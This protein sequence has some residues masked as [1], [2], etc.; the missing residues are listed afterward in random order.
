MTPEERLRELRRRPHERPPAIDRPV[1]EVP[2]RPERNLGPRDYDLIDD[3]VTSDGPPVE[4][5]GV[6]NDEVERV[7]WV[8]HNEAG[9]P[10]RFESAT[11]HDNRRGVS[12]GIRE[13][14]WEGDRCV[15]VRR[16][17]SDGEYSW[18]E[19]DDG[20][21]DERGLVLVRRNGIL[22]WNRASDGIEE[23][24]LPADEALAIWVEAAAEAA[25]RAVEFAA[26]PEGAVIKV[27]ASFLAEPPAVVI[28]DPGRIAL[29]GAREAVRRA[30]E[31]SLP[32]IRELSPD[33]LHALRSL[34]TVRVLD[35]WAEAG[36]ALTRRLA[37]MSWP[38]GAIAVGYGLG[39]DGWE[40]AL[41][42]LPAA[43]SIATVGG[44][45]SSREEIAD[46]LE[47][48]GLP[49][50]LAERAQ[51]GLLLV[52]GGSGRS[53]LG[54]RAELPEGMP[55][56]HCEGRPLTHLA[57]IAL[58]E[59]PD[60]EGRELL[61]AEGDLVF[62]ADLSYEGELWEPTIVGED[63]RVVVLHVVG[64]THEPAP[65]RG[66]LRQ[67]AIR[68]RPVL[69]MPEGE[70]PRYERLVDALHDQTPELFEP[71]H[72]LLGHPAAFVQGDPREPGQVSLLHL[73]WDEA[74]GFEY[75]DGADLT[76]YGDAGDVRAGRW[77]RLTVEPQSG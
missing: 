60:F 31:P 53:R 62:F 49:R 73:G 17:E 27:V 12:I 4:L 35:G 24:P 65:P 33:G 18:E 6:H 9:R 41:A 20:E 39:D 23:N 46:L 74:L 16:R 37:G 61:P 58:P 75:L 76:F 22:V 13:C 36:E 2:L 40:R 50:E 55:W 3:V 48:S 21:Y 69:T 70:D 1:P 32:L 8:H 72:L 67:R 25:A 14:D 15:R 26:I 77:D 5:V 66:Q 44:A 42:D 38:G 52:G 68:F 59:L 64:P 29:E 54:G 45:P 57:T 19:V 11:I 56:P 28:V 43:P 10:V 30:N 34:R 47:D 71:G 51:W 7:T 63:D